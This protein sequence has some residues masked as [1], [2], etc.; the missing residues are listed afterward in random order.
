MQSTVFC[1]FWRLA[2]LLILIELLILSFSRS[3]WCPRLSG[4]QLTAFFIFLSWCL[5]LDVDYGILETRLWPLILLLFHLF[6]LIALISS[7][8]IVQL[9]ELELNPLLVA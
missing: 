1:R 2:L 8:S 7:A 5:F 3:D 4:A 6:C 9:I